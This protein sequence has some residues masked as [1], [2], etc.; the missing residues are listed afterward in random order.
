[1]VKIITSL[2]FLLLSSIA[3]KSQF[4]F[5]DFVSSRQ[6]ASDMQKFKENKIRLV[7]IKSFEEDGSPSDGF[8]GERSLAKDYKKSEIFVRSNVT[9]T[10]LLTTLFNDQGR[11]K[12]SIDS[13]AISATHTTYEY[14]DQDRLKKITTSMR[15]ADDDFVNEIHEQ[16]IYLYED[17]FLPVKM[18]RVKNRADSVT[19]L[20]LHDENNNISLEKD[21]RSGSKYYYYYDEKSRLTD[22]AHSN[23]FKPKLLADYLFEYNAD[24]TFSQMTTTE[25]GGNDYYIWKYKYEDGLRVSEKIYSK[26]RHML[27][28]IQYEYK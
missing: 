13:S 19:I 15:S 9:G 16:H 21:S 6:A 24:G 12:H 27:G 5:K 20:F 23:E 17:E 10:S 7:K 14:D 18:I 4:Y 22:I 25:E 26:E 28:S 8:F 1:M 11:L 3:A 2:S